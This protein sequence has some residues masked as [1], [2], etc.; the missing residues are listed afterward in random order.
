MAAAASAL[1]AVSAL[2]T[3]S[4]NTPAV[5]LAGQLTNVTTPLS[6]DLIQPGDM[7]SAG[8]DISMPGAHPAATVRVTGVVVSIPLQCQMDDTRSAASLVLRLP[9]MAESFA[10]TDRGWQ[11]TASP[12]DARGYQVSM[13]AP[14][15]CDHGTLV[16]GG[17][18]AYSAML[19]SADTVHTFAMRFH[20]VDA[21][22]NQN[23]GDQNGG[24]QNGGDQGNGNTSAA[25]QNRGNH[26][27]NAS[28]DD[29]AP[30]NTNCALTAENPNGVPQCNAP[31][32]PTTSAIA[33]SP[34]GAGTGSG[35]GDMEQSLAQGGLALV[36]VAHD[37]DGADPFRRGHRHAVGT[38]LEV[39]LGG[40]W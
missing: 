24:N 37:G 22:A 5:H 2:V 12:A 34:S 23:G 4:A 6:G 36:T 26:S 19:L 33:A 32:T 3:A 17:P 10:A 29:S 13:A 31:W 27:S 16:G 11:P 15:L 9:D 21:R 14:L 7:I 35:P 1:L 8:W 39:C 30:P 25:N 18:V 38:P 40:E 20:S 28:H